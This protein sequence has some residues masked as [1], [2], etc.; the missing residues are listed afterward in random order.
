[1][2]K[3][4]WYAVFALSFMG[5]GMTLA[6]TIIGGKVE[7]LVPE[8]P[9]TIDLTPA[10]IE[11]LKA[12]VVDRLLACE[13]AGHTEDYGLVTFDQ[14]KA[15]T[16]SSRNTPSFGIL[17]FKVTTVQAF[18][19]KQTGNDITGK[20]AILLALDAKEARALASYVIFDTEGGIFHWAN[21]AEKLKLVEEVTVLKKLTN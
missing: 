20:E 3:L 11:A 19:K 5:I 12:D 13:S 4:Y 9:K 8:L 1:M 16:L 18:V 10:K 21:C 7:A 15:G 6:G 17:Q 14:N 2:K